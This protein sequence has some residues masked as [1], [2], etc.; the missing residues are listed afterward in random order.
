MHS[1]EVHGEKAAGLP[2]VECLSSSPLADTILEFFD[3]PAD[4]RMQELCGCGAEV[5]IVPQPWYSVRQHPLDPRDDLLSSL[6][7]EKR[8]QHK[9]L[10]EDLQTNN[11]R[12]DSIQ[13]ACQ[14]EDADCPLQTLHCYD[15]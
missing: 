15:C 1:V 2:C 9:G 8:H 4:V 5:Q 13:A 10:H 6:L 14:M 3:A 12:Q 11:V 7:P